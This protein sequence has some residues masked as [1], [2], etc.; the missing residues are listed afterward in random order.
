MAVETIRKD[1]KVVA[2][3]SNVYHKGLR[4]VGQR[5][6]TK[7]EAQLDELNQKRAFLTGTHF[8]ETRKSLDQGYDDYL[9]LIAPKN[10][11]AASLNTTKSYYKNHIKPVFGH[12]EMVSITPIE[13]QKFLTKKE[14]ELA[15][16]SII[17][18]HTLLNQIYKTMIE[19]GELKNNPLKGV[20]APPANHK[21]MEVWS[22]EEAQKFLA[23]AK[24]Y[25]AYMAFWLALNFGLR[26]SE[27][28][29]LKWK[30][31]NFA[32]KSMYINRGHHESDPNE[33]QL[34]SRSAYRHIAISN[35]Q[36]I[37]LKKHKKKQ[38]EVL[39]SIGG[40]Q[41]NNISLVV[42]TKTGNH[43][44]QG[45]IRSTM[46]RICERTG[47]KLI[48]FHELRHTHATILLEMNKHAKIVQE[49][50]GHS[51]SSTTIDIYSHVSPKVHEKTSEE[52]SSFFES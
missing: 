50:L 10:L 17:K 31:I 30:D 48:S 24:E 38:L 22:R 3:R 28:L 41:H 6:R 29:G 5:R 44:L 15:N 18:L 21:P 12:R 26:F 4:Y 2:Y 7:E 35:H 20:K 14:E 25:Q 47:V 43:M 23:T 19:W 37:V 39:N 46:K 36:L 49:R 52:F 13:F 51:K 8:E 34:K 16:A 9:T 40:K 27:V 33:K 11:N 1:G 45:N 42:S 32:N